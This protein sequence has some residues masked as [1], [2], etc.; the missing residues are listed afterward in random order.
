[1]DSHRPTSLSVPMNLSALTN[2]EFNSEYLARFID[3]IGIR[4]LLNE[5]IPVNIGMS[6]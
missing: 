4:D 1:M 5:N 2:A 6:C 3:G